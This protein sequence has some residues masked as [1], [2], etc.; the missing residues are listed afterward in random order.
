MS[1]IPDLLEHLSSPALL[2]LL[3]PSRL[4]G[5]AVT[6]LLNQ[7]NGSDATLFDCVRRSEPH[8]SNHNRKNSDRVDAIYCRAWVLCCRSNNQQTPAPAAM[9]SVYS[10]GSR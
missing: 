7:P 9:A 1:S 8:V 5:E 6:L 2:V 3:L 10:A 4:S